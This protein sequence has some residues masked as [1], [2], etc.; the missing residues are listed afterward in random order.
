MTGFATMLRVSLRIQRGDLA[1]PVVMAALPLIL[2]PFLL[3]GAQA[4][5][6]ASGYPSATGA[7][8]VVPGFAALFGFLAVQQIVTGF[9]R[10]HQWGTWERLRAAPVSAGALVLGRSTACLLV[11]LAQLTFVIAVGALVFGYR[12]QG[13]PAAIALV[14]LALAV[15]L[16]AFGVMLVAVFPSSEHALVA[17]SLGGM[18]MAGVGGALAPVS[19]FPGW[20]QAVAHASPAYWALDAMR[21]LSLEP[22]GLA[23]VA[24][25][26]G[27]LAGFTTAF[28]LVA[29]LRFRPAQRK[30][31]LR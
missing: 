24:P 19:S 2:T 26:L 8:Q 1:T 18:V 30:A 11:Q 21:T 12:P 6:Q 7:E 28:A 5:L 17:A 3:P 14:L 27:A 15:M 13:S 23:D 25:A 4:Q 29:A 31:G 10:E 22:A 16:V 20:A 9:G